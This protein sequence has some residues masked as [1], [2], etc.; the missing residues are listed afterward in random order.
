MSDYIAD[1]QGPD[2]EP[3]TGLDQLVAHILRGAKPESDWVVG[4]E[5]ERIGVDPDT[6]W[7]PKNP[8]LSL[9]IHRASPASIRFPPGRTRELVCSGDV[10]VN[11]RRSVTKGSVRILY[12]DRFQ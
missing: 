5:V 7:L 8:A 12:L 9:A 10:G 3:I 6:G 11:G 1:E 2:A 4:T